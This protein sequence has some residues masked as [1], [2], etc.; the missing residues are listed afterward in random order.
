[1]ILESSE[2]R[3]IE[4]VKRYRIGA[5]AWEVA[6]HFSSWGQNQARKEL[7]R[8]VEKGFLTKHQDAGPSL[9]KLKKDLQ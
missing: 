8:L 2:R 6:C 3:V 4:V 1:M 5:T 7:N 9:Y